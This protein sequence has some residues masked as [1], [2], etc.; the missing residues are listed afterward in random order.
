MKNFHNF[1]F[2]HYAHF[3]AAQILKLYFLFVVFTHTYMHMYVH[4][5]TYVIHAYI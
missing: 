1:I 5:G 3:Y 2:S 4:A